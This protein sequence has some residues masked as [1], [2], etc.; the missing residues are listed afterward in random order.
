MAQLPPLPTP[1]SEVADQHY[2]AGRY[3]Q[4]ALFYQAAVARDSSDWRSTYQL[5]QTLR[6]LF[7][8]SEALPHYRRVLSNAPRT[9]PAAEFYYALLLQ[10][11]QRC[12]EALPL[13]H[14]FA[15][16]YPDH[17]LAEQAHSLQQ[18]CYQSALFETS[19]AALDL[20]ALPAPFNTPAHDYA[21]VPY[22]HDSSLVL[23][24]GRWQSPHRALDARYGENYT[25]LY[26]VEHSDKGVRDQS[27]QVARWNSP[28]HDGPGCFNTPRTKFYFT[29]CRSDYC[30]IYVSDYRQGKWRSPVPLGAAVNAVGSNSKHPALSPGGDTLFFASDRLG[31]QGGLDLWQSVRDSATAWRPAVNLGETINT[32]G[33]EI[34]PFYYGSE[35]ILLFASSGHGGRG[36]MDL[37]GVPQYSGGRGTPQL[38][39]APF[40]SG[41]DDCFLVLGRHHGYLS[42]NRTGNFDV[43]SFAPDTL[44]S[45]AQQLLPVT[46]RPPQF[47]SIQPPNTSLED[48]LLD[49]DV[50]LPAPTND[51]VVVRS[52]PEERLSNGSSRFVLA[53]DVNEIALSGPQNQT[54]PAS[55]PLPERSD[56]TP[57]LVRRTP[58][59]IVS[60]EGISSDRRSEATGTL[61]QQTAGGR[62]SVAHTTVH[63]LDS[64]GAVAKITTTNEA[65][66]FHFVNLSPATRYALVVGESA[67][68]PDSTLRLRDFALTAYEESTASASYETLYFDFNQRTLRPEAAQALRELA[69]FYAQH[70]TIVIEVNAFADSLGNDAYNLQLS[71]QRGAAVIDYLVAQRVS[72]SA[73]VLNAEGVSTAW[74]STNSAVSQQ[75]NRRVEIHLVG[76]NL[77]YV[78]QTETRILRPNVSLKQLSEVLGIE[79][80]QLEQMNG[81]T[82]DALL[83][84]KPLRIPRIRNS[85]IKPFF[86]IVQQD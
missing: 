76:Q 64:A 24:S 79:A 10:Q 61:Y 31:G 4:A 78:P 21:A 50:P 17:P 84:L 77:R 38:L 55:A 7:R 13:L 52:V 67:S 37:Y 48:L 49:Y 41:Q 5:A 8:Y 6:H 83:P 46:G 35:D 19:P 15:A 30:R 69:Q 9:Y 62:G 73:L 42:S 43:Y 51:I 58:L 82:I 1:S 28:G 14:H 16:T 45:L 29:R 47:L 80:K 75:L 71:R 74:S 60:T 81:T 68:F 53:S 12:A 27:G 3:A 70:P 18:S 66:Q 44:Q 23:T 32:T 63:L 86:F 26:W 20:V 56:A 2:Q 22:R 40:N 34:A 72:R 25:N 54:T 65:G 33:D 57:T 36:G 59:M 85:A 39:R 11:R